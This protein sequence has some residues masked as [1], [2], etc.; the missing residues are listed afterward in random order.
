MT[1]LLVSVGIQ[2]V[3][4][5]V[6]VIWLRYQTRRHFSSNATID[7]VR[8]EVNSLLVELD[9]SA[10]RNINI[11]EDRIQQLR[12]A[13]AEADR[14]LAV[15][16]Q[17]TRNRQLEGGV[18]NRLGQLHG[19]STQ[20]GAPA[21]NGPAERPV[22]S[23]SA[24][25]RSAQQPA[26]PRSAAPRSA[27]PRSAA[28]YSF[29]QNLS[30][31]GRSPNQATDL[32]AVEAVA[33]RLPNAVGRDTSDGEAVPF[34]HLSGNTIQTEASFVDRGLDL[35]KRGFSPDIIAAKTRATVAEVDIVVSMDKLRNGGGDG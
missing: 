16:L 25:D 17:E 24:A 13:T 19:R 1:G 32:P 15:L 9:A 35:H 10:E 33:A 3:F 34:I 11:I 6:V 8:Q 23:Q 14:K 29:G 21:A 4:C 2:L 5:V 12:A 18:Y 26:A 30:A 31:D 7:S 22:T 28:P 27:A 20:D